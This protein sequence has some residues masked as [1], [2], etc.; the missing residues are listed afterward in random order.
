MTKELDDRPRPLKIRRGEKKAE[1]VPIIASWHE[2]DGTAHHQ[3]GLSLSFW[4]RAY[5]AYEDKVAELMLRKKGIVLKRK[6]VKS[7]TLI[8]KLARREDA[9]LKNFPTLEPIEEECKQIS[10]IPCQRVSIHIPTKND[11]HTQQNQE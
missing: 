10:L 1:N 11:I 4:D 3:K 9:E 2:K 5:D 8:E 7:Q 6:S